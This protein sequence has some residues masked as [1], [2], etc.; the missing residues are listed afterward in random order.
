MWPANRNEVMFSLLQA[1]WERIRGVF[2]FSLL[3]EWPRICTQWLTLPWTGKGLRSFPFPKSRPLRPWGWIV[4]S[5]F[6]GLRGPNPR[7]SKSGR[8]G[9]ERVR[10]LHRAGGTQIGLVACVPH[11]VPELESQPKPPQPSTGNEKAGLLGPQLKFSELF[12]P[13]TSCITSK[14]EKEWISLPH[15]VVGWTYPT[16]VII[17]IFDEQLLCA[18]HLHIF[19]I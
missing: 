5:C 14:G 12:K 7:A 2:S 6:S 10:N 8:L 1:I 15:C 16:I 18:W 3:E 13:Y 11:C 9:P 19:L 17:N 4:S